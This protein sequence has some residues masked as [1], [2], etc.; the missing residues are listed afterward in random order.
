MNEGDLSAQVLDVFTR[1]CQY[2]PSR[3]KEGSI[4]R[5]LPRI[6]RTLSDAANLPHVVQL[7]L[8]FDPVLVE[9]VAT[10][11]FHLL[12]DNPALPRF[13]DSGAFFFILMYTGIRDI[14]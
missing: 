8:T 4:V 13:Y 10:L 2:F 6:K 12:V 11:L 9:K 7:L 5:P 14:S 3:D 1:I